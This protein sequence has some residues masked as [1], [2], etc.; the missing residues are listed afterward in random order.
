MRKFLRVHTAE[1]D[2]DATIS[3]NTNNWK[4]KTSFTLM[5]IVAFSSIP[6]ADAETR[7]EGSS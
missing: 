4:K 6:Q 7:E 3:I 5:Q 2:V 1:R